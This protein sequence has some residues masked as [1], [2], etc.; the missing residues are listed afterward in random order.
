MCIT[1]MTFGG[2]QHFKAM[3]NCIKYMIFPNIFL[4]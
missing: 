2:V 3:N 4:K 1:L